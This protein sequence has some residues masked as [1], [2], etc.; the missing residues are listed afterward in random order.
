MRSRF[1]TLSIAILFAASACAGPGTTP[2]PATPAP[3]TPS[4]AAQP[5]GTPDAGGPTADPADWQA[6]GGSAWEELLAAARAEGTVVIG[7]PAFLA[8]PMAEAFRRDTGITLEWI[9]ASGAEVSAR[10]QQ[11]V[12]AG[13]VTIDGK[14]GGAQELFVDWRNILEPVKPQLILPGVTDGSNWRRGEV[15]FYDPDKA[16]MLKGS[17]YVFGWPVVNSDVI[18][19]A[20]IRTWDDLLKPEYRGKIASADITTPSPGQGAAHGVYNY[21]GLDFVRQL[22]I[23]Q[24]VTFTLDNS[25]LVEWAARGT[26]PIILGSIQSQLERFRAQGFQNLVPILPE[27]GP[28][29]LTSGFSVFVQPKGAPHP[30][31][32]RVFMNWYASRPG[33]ETYERLMLEASARTDV[34]TPSL[35]EYVRPVDGKDYWVDSDLD[36]FL[37]Q[38]GPVSGQFVEMVGGR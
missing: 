22:Y 14:L 34:E 12:A 17:E 7:G 4:P 27:D 29:Y 13:N 25:Q 21:K 1:A 36:W 31:A 38:R 28:G 10:M 5:T 19:P 26:Y 11:E 33:Q 16:Y 2:A 6:G 24:E 8:E 23:D 32:A 30:N 35:P 3:A 18:D 37:T 15:P 20:S 9:G